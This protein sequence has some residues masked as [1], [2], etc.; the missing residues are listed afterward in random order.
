MKMYFSRFDYTNKAKEFK[1]GL[2]KK[3]IDK[4]PNEDLLA[5]MIEAW[6]VYIHMTSLPQ[7]YMSEEKNAKDEYLEFYNGV[8]KRMG[9]KN[10][11]KRKTK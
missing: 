9:G 7:E 3:Q 5:M 1:A 10:K 2:R 11:K 8:L 4:S 6:N